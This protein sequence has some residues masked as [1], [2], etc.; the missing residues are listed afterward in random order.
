MQDDANFGT[1]GTLVIGG[2]GGIGQ[3]VCAAFAGAGSDVALTYRSNATAAEQVQAVIEAAGQRSLARPVDITDR[4]AV[5]AMVDESAEAFGGLHTVV[6]AMGADISMT[7]VSGIDDDEWDRTIAGDLT[8][9]YNVLKAAIPHLQKSRG[10][11]V[12]MTSAALHRYAQ[13]DVLSAVPKAGVEVLIRGIAR[14]E[15]RSG[16]R[17]NS[18]ALGVIDGG[19]FHRLTERVPPEFV[20]AMKRNTALRRFGTPEEA[21]DLAVFLA[22]RKAAYITGQSIALDGGYSI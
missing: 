16:V 15:G 8:G 5:R 6:I 12:A 11:V 21:A 13:K 20:E 14:E 2:S 4:A 1:G 3:A 9:C 7:Y 22:S 19:L 18:I 17:A 10:S